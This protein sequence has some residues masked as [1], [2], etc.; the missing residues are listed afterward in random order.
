MNDAYLNWEKIKRVLPKAR[1]YAL[2]RILVEI[3]I[4]EEAVI[5]GKALT[6]VLISSGIREGTIKQLKVRHTYRYGSL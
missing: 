4:V 1:R 2:D 6:P 3:R 5:R